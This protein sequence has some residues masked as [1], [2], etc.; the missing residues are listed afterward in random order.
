VVAGPVHVQP[1][2]HAPMSRNPSEGRP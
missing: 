2:R 1:P